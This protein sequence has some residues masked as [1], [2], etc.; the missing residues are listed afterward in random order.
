MC[1][2]VEE[3]ASDFMVSYGTDATGKMGRANDGIP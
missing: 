1:Y 3:Q 2:R